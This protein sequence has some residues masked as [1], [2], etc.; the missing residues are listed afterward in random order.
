M[1]SE[2]RSSKSQHTD[3]IFPFETGRDYVSILNLEMMQDRNVTQ[4]ATLPFEGLMCKSW[5]LDNE[6][7][8]DLF[9]K[10]AL[11]FGYHIP[12]ICGELLGFEAVVCSFDGC[13]GDSV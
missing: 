8:T 1:Y 5:D 9:V 11:S 13:H 10:D 7:L 12:E 4:P 6:Y 2:Q 3:G